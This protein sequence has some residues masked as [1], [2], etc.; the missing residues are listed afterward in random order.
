MFRKTRE[1]L[2]YTTR[3]VLCGRSADVRHTVRV[4]MAE[5]VA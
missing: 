2:F 1:V 3:R 5:Y 4:H